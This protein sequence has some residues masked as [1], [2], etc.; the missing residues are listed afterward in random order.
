MFE[1][2][3][4]PVSFP[5]L[6]RELLRFWK[7]EGIFER[8]VEQ[9]RGRPRF[10]F[11][12]GPPTANNAPHMGHVLTRVAKDVFLRYRTMCGWHVPRRSGWDTHGLPV[13]I[14]V[15]KELGIHGKREIEQ[16]GIEAFTRRCIESVWR[17]IGEWEQMSERVGFWLDQEGY[18]TYHRYYVESVWWAL[19]RFFKQGLLYQDYKSVWWWPQGGTALSQGEVG[20][21]YRPIDD[22]TVVVRFRLDK[23]RALLAWT[24]TPW[25][26]PSNLALAVAPDETYVEA[27][28]NGETLIVAQ[29]LAQDVLEGAYTIVRE[30]KGRELVGVKYEPLY[31]YRKP[32]GGKAY[33]IGAADFVTLDTGTGVVH[34]APAF[35]EDDHRF[36]KEQGFAFL[37]LVEPDGR[38][39]ADCGEIAGMYIKDADKVITRDLEE[40]GLLYSQG[41]YR[42]DYPFC[43]RAPQDPL[44]QYARRSWFIR[45]S[46]EKERVLANNAAVT[47]Q[48]PHIREGR[49]GDF[50]RNNVD[51]AISRERWWG[52]PLPIWVNDE[53]GE[54]DAIASV[55]EILERNPDA[56]RHF[57][58][59]KRRNPDLDDHLLVH[60][61]WIDAV[62]WTR[63]G[64]PGV[65]R[66]VPEVIDCWFDAGAMPFAQWGYPHRNRE[67][68]AE[69]FPAEFITEA[70]D[71]T[72]GWWNALLQIS[73]LLFPE[74]ERPHPFR[75]CV[76]LGH[77]TDMK[78]RKLSKRL[79]N[80]EP[81][82]EAFEHYGADAV[83]WALLV[84]CVPGV[85]TRFE[86]GAATD[87]V[88]DL[89][90]KVWNVYAFFVTYARID[91]WRPGGAPPP[92][93]RATL[94]RWVLAELDDTVR[95][96]RE[97]FENLESHTAARRIQAFV[98]A[99]SNW[100]VRRSRPRFWAEGESADKQAAFATLLE[101][102][103]EL[104]R[105][106]APF[107]P[108]L[109]ETLHQEL[110]RAAD[111]EAPLSVHLDRYPEEQP[112]RQD[113][114]LRRSMGLARDL[115]VLGL[116]VRA[117]HRIKVRQPLAEAILVLAGDEELFEETI[118]EELNVKRIRTSD[119]PAR[120]VDFT[121]VPNFRAL[122]PTLGR[123][124][125]QCKQALAEADGAGLFAA[126]EQKGEIT[127]EL[128]D[129]QPIPLTR[130]EVE[131][132][133]TAREGYA[134]ASEG[135]RVVVLDTRITDELRREGLAREVINRIQTA[136]KAMDLPYEAR[137][138][139]TYRAGGEVAEAIAAHA[140]WIA[141]E[142]LA[143]RLEA[144]EP[145]GTLHEAEVEG[146]AFRFGIER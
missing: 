12:E 18:A 26:L 97:A 55:D 54:M 145:A 4:S 96:V 74:A 111:A 57:E 53:T 75:S 5:G 133:L 121:I 8:S 29:A 21:G 31:Q 49:M 41:T 90:L 112:A 99:L 114:A 7:Q 95:A 100:Y 45:T 102:L 24:T 139:I 108:F 65:Y 1:P 107:T 40:R 14:E 9:A 47:W 11:F 64:E 83:R 142:T 36:G 42:H 143:G 68:F 101:V 44:I 79:K 88:R 137:I 70:I 78:G 135:G 59:A 125:P 86:G 109:A 115:V 32:E 127:L 106:L 16:L 123:R 73:S 94:D 144:G 62:T 46:T 72:R 48:P 92:A 132:R 28:Q 43:P 58:E 6:E 67:A 110:V 117:T 113:D 34:I 20:E 10:T 63:D 105:L 66:R 126:L 120:Y 80:Y 76:V 82:M 25:T 104:A 98:D 39:A 50:L 37:Q 118:R 131:V 122:G 17:Y 91:D 30:L 56:F 51:W 87:A 129:G 134:A 61:P 124:M 52:T 103:G 140:A 85:G 60:R 77:I 3:P 93:E 138:Q 2:V 146:A 35:G 130:D 116:R 22:P 13:E 38:F 119:E 89:L 141:R 23:K 27:E 15:E 84:A 33:E 128:P 81:P 69:A 19:A 71:Q 136:R